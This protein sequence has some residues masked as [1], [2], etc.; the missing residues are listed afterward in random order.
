MGKKVASKRLN[1]RVGPKGVKR[2]LT[3]GK[4]VRCPCWGRVPTLTTP[5]T[6]CH[7]PPLADH[8]THL[9]AYHSE[10]FDSIDRRAASPAGIRRDMI[11]L[12]LMVVDGDQDGGWEDPSPA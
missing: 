6:S 5:G 10:M 8:P 7:N 9:C 3:P 4:V 1:G 2:L 11:E 12:D